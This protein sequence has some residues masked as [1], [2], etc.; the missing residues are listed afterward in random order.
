MPNAIVVNK[1]GGPDVLKW[2]SV[3]MPEPAANEVLIRHTAIGVNFIDIYF[4]TGLYKA[5]SLPF[6]PGLEGAG[7][8]EKC[9]EEVENYGVGDRVAYALGPLGGY[10]EYRTLATTHLVKIPDDVYDEQ[11]AGVM[12]RGLTA[13]FLLRH[14]FRVTTGHRVLIHSAAGGVGLLL[15][16]WARSLGAEVIG[17]VGSDDKKALAEDYG[18]H[19]VINYSDDNWVEQ[20]IA[21][22]RGKKVHVVYDSVGKATF[23]GSLDCLSPF[24]MMVSYGQ[25]SGVVPPFDLGILRDK[26]SLF[27]TRPSLMDYKNDSGDYMVGALELFDMIMT[28]KLRVN[29]GQTYYL[30]DAAE[31]HRDIEARKTVGSTVL[32]VE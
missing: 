4:R 1:I 20:V 26:G 7:I 25:S 16:Q 24:G 27:L 13:H 6:I 8:I 31:A 21:A 3:D 2:Q 28:H 15:C 17:T 23:N 30:Q 5:P 14:T 22:S 10:S 18:C 12:V 9:G 29:I 32:I 19:H 11:A